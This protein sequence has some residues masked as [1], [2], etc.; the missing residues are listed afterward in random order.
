MLSMESEQATMKQKLKSIDQIN[1]LQLDK[2]REEAEKYR[3]QL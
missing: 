2:T 1:K 3:I